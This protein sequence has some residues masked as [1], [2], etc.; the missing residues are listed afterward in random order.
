MVFPSTRYV[1]DRAL[2]REAYREEDPVAPRGVYAEGKWRAEQALVRLA[3]EAGLG[4]RVARLANLYGPDGHPD[5]VPQ[6]ALAQAVAGG[7][8]SLRDPGP[9]RDFLHVADA[10]A[11]LVALALAPDDEAAPVVYNVASGVG[12]SVGELARLV[13]ALAGLGAPSFARPPAAGPPDRLVLANRR[14]RAALGWVPRLD[15]RAGLEQS[16]EEMRAHG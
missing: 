6:R 7:P 8:L 3:R 16:L 9:V 15:L 1:Y 13:A 2:G 12:T 14:I 5:T 11:A 10:A 4:L